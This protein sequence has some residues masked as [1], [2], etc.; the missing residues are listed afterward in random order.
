[1]PTYDE[2]IHSILDNLH[3]HI[4]N[5][6]IELLFDLY[7]LCQIEK[8]A[9]TIYE[10]DAELCSRHVSCDDR[11]VLSENDYL[12]LAK[13]TKHLHDACV[14]TDLESILHEWSAD[15]ADIYNMTANEAF[16][17]FIDAA[18]QR[19]ADMTLLGVN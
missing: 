2:H 13:R 18:K 15:Y 16:Q 17:K 8:F 6:N 10:E 12:C 4:T 5:M 14:K 7:L 9:F 1:M 11:P 3:Q 19:Y